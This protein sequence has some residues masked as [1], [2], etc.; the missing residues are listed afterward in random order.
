[1][2]GATSAAVCRE[3]TFGEKLS[4][5]IRPIMDNE[6]TVYM[7]IDDEYELLDIAAQIV[8]YRRGLVDSQQTTVCIIP[9]NPFW[10]LN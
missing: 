8:E 4:K 10:R 1:M 7:D 5:H 9:R 6:E 3:H 2:F